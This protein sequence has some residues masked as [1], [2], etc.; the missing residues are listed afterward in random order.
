MKAQL[1]NETHVEL[2]A[3]FTARGAI[4]DDLEVS[5]QLFNRWSRAVI[6][7]YEF[8]NTDPIRSE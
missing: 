8:A 7:R 5:V 3:G 6:G 1:Q 4:M 2:P